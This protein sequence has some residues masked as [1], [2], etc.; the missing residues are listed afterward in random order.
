[1]VDVN[2]RLMNHKSRSCLIE[3]VCEEGDG[4]DGGAA[5]LCNLKWPA[6]PGSLKVKVNRGI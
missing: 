4:G 3:M 2:V 6:S 1:M 5:H